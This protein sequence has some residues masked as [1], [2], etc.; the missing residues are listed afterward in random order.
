[1]AMLKAGRH[2]IV[3]RVLVVRIV[4]MLVIVFGR[5]MEMPMHMVLRQM[6]P[7]TERHQCASQD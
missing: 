7:D 1:M 4:N 5:L 3:V 2:G 6:Q